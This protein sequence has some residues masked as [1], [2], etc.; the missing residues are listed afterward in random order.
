MN[1]RWKYI[2]V[3]FFG[4]ITT[5]PGFAQITVWNAEDLQ[6]QEI[7]SLY[8]IFS[9]TSGWTNATNDDATIQYSRNGLAGPGGAWWTVYVNGVQLYLQSWD[10][11]SLH[12][13]PVSISQIDSLVIVESP[14]IREGNFTDKG[15]IFIYTKEQKKGLHASGNMVFGNRSGDPGPFVYTEYASRNIERLGPVAD[16][17]ISYQKENYGVR[18]GFK[19]FVHAV[20]D[21][22]AFRRMTPF[23]FGEGRFRHEK[24]R[25]TSFF[26]EA[27]IHTGIFE[28]GIQGGFTQSSD[29]LFTGLYGTEIPVDRNRQFAALTGKGS[30]NESVKVYYAANFNASRMEEYPNKEDRWLRWNQDI[31][32]GKMQ[33]HQSF[34]KGGQKTGIEVE[35]YKLKDEE[36]AQRTLNSVLFKAFHQLEYTINET[37]STRTNLMITSGSSVALKANL[38]ST[39]RL[40]KDHSLTLE[41]S[42]SQRLPDED[43]SIWFWMHKKGFASDTL[44]VYHPEQLPEKSTF[45]QLQLGWKA[46]I[47]EGIQLQVDPSLNQNKNEYLLDYSLM[48]KGQRIETAQYQFLDDL[49]ASFFKL[50][51]KLEINTHPKI[52]Q[53]LSYTWIEQLSGKARFFKMQP[54]HRLSTHVNWMPVSSFKIWTRLQMQSETSWPYAQGIDGHSVQI[55]P[56]QTITYESVTP[57]RALLDIG[58]KKFFWEQRVAFSLDLK[59][60]TDRHYR[61]HPVSPEHAFSVFLGMHMDL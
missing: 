31:V 37:L 52:W 7:H 42:Y 25:S 60:I 14:D 41:G 47:F 34:K 53:T 43:N 16:G 40:N 2:A 30:V 51:V 15:G 10:T 32:S 6:R 33:L 26:G 5:A 29:F 57:S 45:L 39:F 24:I 44:S 18:A 13:I 21:P 55:N 11:Q 23:D 46:N 54:R 19:H 17:L 8:D 48:P 61:N 3:L 38:G 22:L 1:K 59:N 58:I 49:D 20:T 9:I 28:H 35:Q 56:L 4:V 36:E 12:D 27:D 50:P